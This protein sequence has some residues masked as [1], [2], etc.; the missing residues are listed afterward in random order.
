MRVNRLMDNSAETITGAVKALRER[1]G[2]SIAKLAKAAGYKGASSFQRYEDPELYGGGYLKRDLVAML[3][4]ALV[5]RGSPPIR[6]QEV[7][8]LAGPEFQPKFGA[9]GK[10]E[11]RD[12][13]ETPDFDSSWEGMTA[14]LI[15][16]SLHYTPRL[17]GGK[18]EFSASPGMGDGEFGD[19]RAMAVSTKGIATGHIVTGEW[20]VPD[21]Y[22]RGTLGGAPRQIAVL[23]VVG[24]SM[25][26]ML[27]SNDRAFVDLSQ[28][29]YAG[30]AVYVI[31]NGDTVFEAKTLRKV[32][33]KDPA[34]FQIISEARPEREVF[35]RADEFRIIGRVIGRFTK[36]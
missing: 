14:A 27:E 11:P 8:A 13:G 30:E 2:L 32:D 25:E 7:W 6:Q 24:H 35:R 28:N 31:D 26:P 1:S 3:A 29:V 12:P 17:P 33:N 16:G 19:D 4:K 9:L 34:M 10:E 20:V 5:G 23:P 18:P 15:G 36:V 21:S 22:L